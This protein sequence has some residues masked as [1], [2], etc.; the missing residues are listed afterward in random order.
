[1]IALEIVLPDGNRDIRYNLE[2]RDRCLVFRNP[3]ELIVR[4]RLGI[5]VERRG[6]QHLGFRVSVEC[7]N[8]GVFH[9]KEELPYPSEGS[10]WRPRPVI[11]VQVR[12]TGAGPREKTKRRV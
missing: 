12:L 2:R 7:V 10:A 6:K 1:M 8:L 9:L 4:S 3:V 5:G 11:R